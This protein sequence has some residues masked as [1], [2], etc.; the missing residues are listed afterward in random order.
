MAHTWHY[1]EPEDGILRVRIERE[2][3]PVNSFARESLLELGELVKHIKGN[4]D[5][6]GV[7]FR[8]GK[9]GNFVAGADINQLRNL[10]EREA[11]RDISRVGQEVFQAL[12]ELD[13]PTVALI[14]GSCVGGGLEFV[15]S[16][17]YRVADTSSKTVLGLPEVKL[18]LIPG[19]GGT[20]RMVRHCGLIT[21][22]PLI[23][24]G[25]FISGK[26]AKSK[27]LVHD[28]V[29]TEALSD[30]GDKIIRELVASGDKVGT[31]K[32]LFR[33]RKKPWL[34]RVIEKN[35]FV[36]KYA[37]NKAEKQVL[38]NTHGHY[39]A[40]LKII[41][42]LRENRE[43]GPK[44]GFL[45]EADAIAELSESPVTTECMRLFF[46]QEKAKKAPDWL[47]AQVDPK[48]IEKA[49][50]LGAGAMGGGIA[51]LLARKG[52]WTRLKDIKPE[53]LSVG[54]Q[55]IRKLLKKDTKRRKL[56]KLQAEQALDHLSPTLDYH[57]L[58]NA[59]IVIEAIV[60]NIDVKR[61]VFDELAAAT[62]PKTVLATNTSSLRVSEICRDV[63][64]PERV[65]GLHF[66]NP[67]HR[68]PLIEIIRHEGSS[69][70]AVATAL[71][72]TNRLGKTGVIVGDCAGFLVNRLLSPYMNEAG[73]LLLETENPMDIE[74]AA[75]DFGMP[76]GPLEL[77]D[78]VGLQVA[79]HVAKNMH[80]AY[81]DRMEPA[82]IWGRMQRESEGRKDIKLVVKSKK[83]EKSI[84]PAVAKIVSTMKLENQRR[85]LVPAKQT[86]VERLIFPIINEAA[87]CLDERI[88]DS[89]DDIDIAMVFGT[90]FAP[91]RG[92][93]MRYA[94]SVGLSHVVARL[95]EFAQTN[96]RLAPSAAL[97]R[98][99]AGQKNFSSIAPSPETAVA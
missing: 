58:K 47:N 89:A 64:H 23:L 72:L 15:M 78:L 31:A 91:F 73:F 74:K 83:G 57:G 24:T 50:V 12:E 97:K 4:S 67:P 52:I 19:W 28:C 53:F 9:T 1:G 14:S 98:F 29:P 51:L 71:A 33:P 32:K 65:V 68:M 22:L 59:D 45:N 63:A 13:V 84:N 55:E 2:G 10:N 36:Q 35:G 77:S 42:V 21:S 90:G 62:N 20:V 11:A 87:I 66:F 81:G 8:S 69:N 34:T 3:E 82:P 6:K 18:G 5:I 39:P 17:S 16:C 93:P 86:I 95:E 25:K 40:P 70:E 56:T 41:Q 75:V 60:E 49:A 94:D 96:P 44:G 61:A 92:G 43:T 27:G 99:A 88:A 26:S 7:V 48:S 85:T 54:M 79:A 76:M 30:V 38:Q 37:L 46:L 80:A